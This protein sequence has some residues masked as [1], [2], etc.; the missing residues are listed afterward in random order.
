[1]AGKYNH[2]VLMS[3]NVFGYPVP[4]SRTTPQGE[5]IVD[6]FDF[7]ATLIR[8]VI[9]PKGGG[10]TFGRPLSA[11]EERKRRRAGGRLDSACHG[12]IGDGAS[13]LC[14]G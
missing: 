5:L 3:G 1:M 8:D 14:L 13:V 2:V 12:S 9:P 10:S 4:A 11:P 7:Y 6:P